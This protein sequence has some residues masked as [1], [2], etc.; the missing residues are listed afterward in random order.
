MQPTHAPASAS[1]A[2]KTAR[3]LIPPMTLTL[4]LTPTDD[5][6]LES[7][8]GEVVGLHLGGPEGRL[9]P[10]GAL[11]GDPGVG[12]VEGVRR[13]RGAGAE[14]VNVSGD[15]HDGGELHGLKRH[16]GACK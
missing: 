4:T 16:T 15:D 14:L 3:D 5:V 13:E 12:G 6:S 1:A 9:G 8:S 10:G 7:P 2:A 11:E